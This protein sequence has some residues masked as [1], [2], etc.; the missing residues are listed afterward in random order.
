L[1][2]H[3]VLHNAQQWPVACRTIV[4]AQTA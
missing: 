1:N 2:R 3:I 4:E